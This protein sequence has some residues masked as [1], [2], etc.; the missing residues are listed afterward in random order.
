MRDRYFAERCFADFYSYF[1]ADVSRDLPIY[2]ELAAKHAGPVLEV[3]CRTGRVAS[4]LGAA[5][6]QV[7]AIDTSRPMLEVARRVLEPWQERVRIVDYDM[8]QGALYEGFGA[9]FATLYTFND[10]IEVEEQRLFLR[11]VSRSMQSP[12]VIALDLFCPLSR[13]RP[14]EVGE[15]R[16]IERCCDGTVVRVRDRREML[17]PLLERRTQVF[18]IEGR[19]ECEITSHRRYVAP[20]LAASLLEEAGF[21]E[22]LWIRGYDLSTAE[23]VGSEARPDGPFLLIARR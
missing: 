7:C 11:H 6:H 15:W 9:V 5:G 17:T 16:T 10:L 12:G 18:Q 20:Q 1:A 8:R 3:G 4:H 21:S 19:P 14:D 2:L 22:V 23:T 13:A